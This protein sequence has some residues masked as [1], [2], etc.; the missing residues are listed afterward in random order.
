MK[1]LV[2]I[3]FCILGY[4]VSNAQT[5]AGSGT[6]TYS[7]T[8]DTSKVMFE[9]NV[10][11]S[12]VSNG[13][14]Y[15]KSK[16]SVKYEFRVLESMMQESSDTALTQIRYDVTLNN[17]NKGYVEFPG[18][19]GRDSNEG[20]GCDLDKKIKGKWYIDNKVYNIILTLIKEEFFAR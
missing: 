9:F 6:I 15:Y 20:Y 2:L 19:R 8:L 14:F 3:T 10:W 7:G 17:Q 16:K 18:Y 11:K 13:S 1:K 4:L 12:R 5:Y